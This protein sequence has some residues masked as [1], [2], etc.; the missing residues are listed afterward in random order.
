MPE[1][2]WVGRQG[3]LLFFFLNEGM[4]DTVTP[5]VIT[6]SCRSAKMIKTIFYLLMNTQYSQRH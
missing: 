6:G 3:L 4:N 2:I 5:I 1:K